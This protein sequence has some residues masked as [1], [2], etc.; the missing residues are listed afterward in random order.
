MLLNTDHLGP[1]NQP[2]ARLQRNGT[3][4]ILYDTSEYREFPLMRYSA[5]VHA[6]EQ[7][8]N[9]YEEKHAHSNEVTKLLINEIISLCRAHNINVVVASL[10]SD[11]TTSDML[12]YCRRSGVQTVNVTV[13]LTKKENNNFPFDSHPSAVAHRLCGT[14]HTV[15]KNGWTSRHSH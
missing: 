15:S 13:D 1:L 10:T 5:F 7:T 6:I 12:D 3:V 8:Y 2:Y 14:A 9:D 11:S 4:E